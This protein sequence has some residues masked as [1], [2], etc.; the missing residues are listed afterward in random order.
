MLVIKEDDYNSL[1]AELQW[2]GEKFDKVMGYFRKYA[3]IEEG[4]SKEKLS[5]LL[6]DLGKSCYTVRG[7]VSSVTERGDLCW[8]MSGS[9]MLSGSQ[10]MC[11][12]GLLDNSTPHST[13][14]PA[15][16]LRLEMIFMY[17]DKGNKGYWNIRD[18]ELLMRDIQYPAE[19]GEKLVPYPLPADQNIS[20][21]ALKKLVDT[22][23][24]RGTSQ[25]LRVSFESGK[26]EKASS[27]AETGQS[28]GGDDKPA[29]SEN[30]VFDVNKQTSD[31][32]ESGLK[33]GDIEYIKISERT[34]YSPIVRER[35]GGGGYDKK[36]VD[37]LSGHKLQVFSPR[38]KGPE[39][40]SP[41]RRRMQ[42]Q[43]SEVREESGMG[44]AVSSP[45]TFVNY[46]ARPSAYQEGVSSYMSRIPLVPNSPS[47]NYTPRMAFRGSVAPSPYY[48]V[49]DGRMALVNRTAPSVVPG[50]V[51]HVP[52]HVPLGGASYH[53]VST[54]QYLNPV[55]SYISPQI[56]VQM[57]KG[58]MD[59]GGSGSP[60]MASSSGAGSEVKSDVHN[61]NK[62][63]TFGQ[64]LQNVGQ[65]I[66]SII[67][68]VFSVP[69][70]TVG[71]GNYSYV[72]QEDIQRR[73][74][75][76]RSS[77]SIGHHFRSSPRSI[78]NTNEQP[79]TR[80]GAYGSPGKMGGGEESNPKMD[81][82][83][84]AVVA[85]P[86]FHST[87]SNEN[88]PMSIDLSKLNV[89]SLPIIP[90]SGSSFNS[91]EVGNT[92]GQ[93]AAGQSSLDEMEK[94]RGRCETGDE[95]RRPV[96]IE[97]VDHFFTFME[98]LLYNEIIGSAGLFGRIL[99][100][101][102]SSFQLTDRE[103]A[104]IGPIMQLTTMDQFMLTFALNC[105]VSH[106]QSGDS[107]AQNEGVLGSGVSIDMVSKKIEGLIGLFHRIY[108]I[109]Y[110]DL[111]NGVERS[112]GSVLGS[113]SNAEQELR[114]SGDSF[115]GYSF[116]PY[117]VK[118]VWE[119]VRTAMEG[120][121][122]MIETI[123]D[124]CVVYYHYLLESNGSFASQ[125]GGRG[126]QESSAHAPRYSSV[127]E[128]I[129]TVRQRYVVAMKMLSLNNSAKTSSAEAKR[130][131]SQGSVK[132]GVQPRQSQP[133]AQ[134]HRASSQKQG[135]SQPRGGEGLNL[136]L[137]EVNRN[138]FVP[139]AKSR[140]T[141]SSPP[142]RYPLLAATSYPNY[143]M[144]QQSKAEGIDGR[145]AV[146][147]GGGSSRRG[148]V[149]DSGEFNPNVVPCVLQ[150]ES[151]ADVENTS[152]H[153]HNKASKSGRQESVSVIG[154]RGGDTMESGQ[155]F[156]FFASPAGGNHSYMNGGGASG[157]GKVVPANIASYCPA[158][159]TLTDK[160]PESR[161]ERK[162][163]IPSRIL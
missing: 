11:L 152:E 153:H 133:E 108:R 114:G 88:Y 90:E 134:G 49:S 126:S 161:L 2:P 33:Q 57:R 107:H 120:D 17:Y 22:R 71:A 125:E 110:Q 54:Q 38:K 149:L 40:N 122:D 55:P 41:S 111:R 106:Q 112:G 157:S 51:Q 30:S 95:A 105:V 101:H 141:D 137:K 91:H 64:S 103:E 39:R 37:G 87:Y 13:S 147:V 45:R 119:K 25:L 65:S 121:L 150:E 113:G 118:M 136:I 8:I 28:I 128:M 140:V 132:G 9:D 68:K 104:L 14:S 145:R 131:R 100:S 46:N 53:H 35:R 77:E 156:V 16:L 15:G 19:N 29:D 86:N 154:K 31:V 48:A 32:Q 4:L 117:I 78:I 23:R 75:G 81:G 109:M 50:A 116:L 63:Q 85:L 18:W 26:P 42:K 59:S 155:S 56:A 159:H 5:K 144:V 34:T 115:V 20:F 70:I 62:L 151:V 10:F 138:V 43:S 82:V 44:Q 162:S 67:P 148:L 6:L 98:Q 143:N 72:S 135:R 47:H 36:F 27:L 130:V 146:A 96:R 124:I 94:Q 163:R 61:L 69:N 97:D 123:K 74:A 158:E 160:V 93:V 3:G 129:E 58:V 7:G 52:Y 99:E 102:E 12:A 84:G 73:G 1:W 92:G 83:L 139:V 24:L 21:E 127:E 142:R 66:M 79:E 76:V 80:G 89:V 60:A